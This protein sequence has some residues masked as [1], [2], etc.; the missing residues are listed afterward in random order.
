MTAAEMALAADEDLLR[1]FDELPDAT[2]W[3]HPTRLWSSER[4]RAGGAIQLSREFG[5]FAKNS[6][7][8]TLG[9]IS[10]LKPTVH[11]Q[12]AGEALQGLAKSDFSSKSV[13]SLIEELDDRGFQSWEFRQDAAT[14]T[15]ELAARDK[16]LPASFL[17]RLE[18]WLNEVAEPAWPEPQSEDSESNSYERTTCILYGP[19]ITSSL[20]HGRGSIIRAIAQ[21]YLKR[22]PPALDGWAE[23]IRSRLTHENTRRFGRKH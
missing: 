9:L 18:T 5:E 23:V 12:Y 1:L 20:T 6:P 19:G 21:G 14:V 13:I 15:E 8:R 17:R 7:T 22:E 11:E 4:S 16:G 10:R 2:R 3:E